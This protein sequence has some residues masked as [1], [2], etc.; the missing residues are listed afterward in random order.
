M[1]FSHVSVLRT[2]GCRRYSVSS[3]PPPQLAAD[4]TFTCIASVYSHIERTSLTLLYFPVLWS[5]WRL[6]GRSSCF[7]MSHALSCPMLSVVPCCQLSH[8]VSCAL[9][10]P[11]LSAVPCLLSGC[12]R[13]L[14]V[15]CPCCELCLAVSCTLL[16]AVSRPSP[17]PGHKAARCVVLVTGRPDCSHSTQP[18]D[19]LTYLQVGSASSELL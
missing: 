11:L 5:Q 6:A 3:P 2:N 9:R 15:S 13:S 18:A 4:T 19:T 16:S 7:V 12:Q 14:A 10:A 17:A 1:R 8:A